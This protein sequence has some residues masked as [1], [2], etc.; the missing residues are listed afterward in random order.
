MLLLFIMIW[1]ADSIGGS[2]QETTC[3]IVEGNLKGDP[4]G[5][6]EN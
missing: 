1:L 3:E 5:E 6:G 2:F 4:V